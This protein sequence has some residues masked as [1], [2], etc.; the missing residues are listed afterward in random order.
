M[1]VKIAFLNGE[2][3]EEVYMNQPRG[4]IM[5]GNEN[6]VCKLIK[7]LYGLK[8]APKQWHQKF[9]EVVLSNGYLLN[10]ANKYV[11]S[12]FDDTGEADVILGIRIKHESN[13]I[14]ISQSYYIEKAVSQLEYSR[15]IGCLMYVMTCT[16][17]D[18]AFA[19]GKLSRLTYTG[20]PLVLEGYTDASWI[21][22]TKDNLSTTGWVFLLSGA[23]VA[24][25]KEAEWLRNLILEIPLRSKP[26]APISICCDSTATLAKAY[27]QMYNGKSRHLGVSHSMIHELITNGVV[28]IEFVRSQQNLVDHLTKGLARDLVLKSAKGIE[29]GDG[30]TGI[31]QHCR[32]QSSDVIRKLTTASGRNRLIS[33]LEDYIP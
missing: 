15:M 30:V 20:Y 14:A 7:S 10:Q 27:S 29:H 16:W 9:D 31:K 6:K 17:P 24:A 13:G 5:P 33:D 19:V 21:S 4:F 1:G 25:G 26:I 8:Q 12:K 3:D 22:N 23:L 28:S 2:L 11:Y 18:I 32:D